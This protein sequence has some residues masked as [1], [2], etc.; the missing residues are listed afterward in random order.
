MA[1]RRTQAQR[2]EETRRAILRAAA[3][4]FLDRGVALTSLDEV[5]AEAGVTKGALYHYFASKDALV[6]AVSAA[7]GSFD[8]VADTES[9][10]AVE[11]GR[12]SAASPPPQLER[13]LSYEL[14]ALSARNEEIRAALGARVRAAIEELAE[15]HDAST[16]QVLVAAALHEGL[17]IHRLLNPDLVTDEVFADAFA[18]LEHL[19]GV[20]DAATPGDR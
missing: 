12:A 17:W 7:L 15:A 4:R 10:T 13:A 11:V 3:D 2:R 16:R 6:A 18:A 9:P 5:A 20:P 8:V 19:R 14:Y 1:G